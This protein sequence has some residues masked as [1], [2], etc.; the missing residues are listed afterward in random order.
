ME[1][2]GKNKNE[3]NRIA[4]QIAGDNE[5]QKKIVMKLIND[6]GFDPYDNGNLDNSWSQQPNSAGYCCDYTCEELKNTKEKSKQTKESV[7]ENRKKIFGNFAELTG[8]DFSHENV[9]KVNRKYNI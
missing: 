6:C 7:K 9:I 2:L 1:N 5:A 3:K 8:G 4:V